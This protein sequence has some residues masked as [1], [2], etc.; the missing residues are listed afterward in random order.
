MTTMNPTLNGDALK[1][2]R[3]DALDDEDLVPVRS[4]P[5]LSKGGAA[6]A[7]KAKSSLAK[8]AAAPVSR[9]LNDDAAKKAPKKK[10][11]QNKRKPVL[12][13]VLIKPLIAKWL[14]DNLSESGDKLKLYFPPSTRRVLAAIAEYLIG[15]LAV[16]AS[17]I[18]FSTGKKTLAMQHVQA[19]LVISTNAD[20]VATLN[21]YA[22]ARI[23][24][25]R[26]HTDALAEAR[27]EREDAPD[28][29]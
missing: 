28:A 13:S 27:A 11:R 25:M 21:P 14:A 4:S 18:T 3:L 16:D 5:R 17:A 23:S 24:D 7:K 26:R 9:V 10:R 6:T 19:A 8:K 20:M 2:K 15:Q 1:R 12:E 29:E 22:I